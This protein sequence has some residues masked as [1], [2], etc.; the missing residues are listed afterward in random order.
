MMLGYRLMKEGCRRVLSLQKYSKKE[1]L[2]IPLFRN[3]NLSIN[4]PNILYHD[5]ELTT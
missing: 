2:K 5:D 1:G 3:I 4:Q